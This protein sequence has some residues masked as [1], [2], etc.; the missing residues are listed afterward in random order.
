MKSKFCWLVTL[1]V[2]M[3]MTACSSDEPSTGLQGSPRVWASTGEQVEFYINGVRKTSV[4]EITVS[5][6]QLGA[7]EPDEFPWYDMTLKVKGLLSKKNKVFEI[8]VQADVERFEGSTVYDGVDYDVTG[9]FTG[10]PFEHYSKMGIIV[11][12]NEKK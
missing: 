10:D 6:L 8:K 5:S 1:V 7:L 4:S 11:S 12:L 2:M 9:V 3:V